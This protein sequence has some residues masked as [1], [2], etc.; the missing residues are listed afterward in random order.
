MSLWA[1]VCKRDGRYIGRCGVYPHFDAHGQAIFGEGTLA[2]YLSRPY[3]GQ[4]L[5]TEAGQALLRHG[6]TVLKL[7]RIVAAV[8][9]GNDASDRVIEKLG[10]RLVPPEGAESR[11]IR[12]YEI[13][14]EA[15][16][17]D[18]AP[19]SMRLD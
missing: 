15:I 5:A 11:G 16:A 4:G 13:L 12:H 18:S 1:T 3:W 6:F 14:P 10:M 7:K 2:I 19:P 8:Q 17:L 9:V